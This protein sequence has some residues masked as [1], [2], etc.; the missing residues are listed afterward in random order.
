MSETFIVYIGA[1]AVQLPDGRV[2]KGPSCESDAARAL[3]ASGLQPDAKLIF[4]RDGRPSL[5]G[6]IVSF[7]ARVW[8]GAADDPASRKWRPYRRQHAP[9]GLGVE[10]TSGAIAM[11]GGIPSSNDKAAVAEGGA[12]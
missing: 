8:A 7:A 9:S 12:L 10:A 11:E 3:L 2:F 4:L 6:N 1:E 5:M